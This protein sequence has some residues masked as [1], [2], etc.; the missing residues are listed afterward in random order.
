MESSPLQED[1]RVGDNFIGPWLALNFHLT[2]RGGLSQVEGLEFFTYLERGQQG[3]LSWGT[4]EGGSPPPLAKK[5]IIPSPTGKVPPPPSRLPPQNF[6]PPSKQQFSCY[7]PIKT[8]YLVV[9]I[10]PVPFL[11]YLYTLC[12]HGHANFDL[13]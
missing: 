11:F 3:F 8:S 9:V 4:M 12:I 1:S 2:L 5:F 10:A 6:Y 13:N 7:N